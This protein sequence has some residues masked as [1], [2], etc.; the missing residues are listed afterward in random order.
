MT[1]CSWM[2]V[3]MALWPF[4]ADSQFVECAWKVVVAYELENTPPGNKPHNYHAQEEEFTDS[5]Y[6]GIEK[7][8]TINAALKILESIALAFYTKCEIKAQDLLCATSEN[9]TSKS[10]FQIGDDFTL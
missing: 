4:F 8:D 1:Q 2:T 10:S 6:E 3:P 7:S 5:E 9:D